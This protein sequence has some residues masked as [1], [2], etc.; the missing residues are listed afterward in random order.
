MPHVWAVLRRADGS[1]G[2]AG[3]VAVYASK[4]CAAARAKAGRKSASGV[5]RCWHERVEVRSDNSA[6][7]DE[8]SNP[9]ESDGGPSPLRSPPPARPH[10]PAD[11][12][13]RQ[14][15]V[16][17]EDGRY[18]AGGS[19]P[20]LLSVLRRCGVSEPVVGLA[21]PDTWCRSPAAAA[22][23]RRPPS[24]SPA[25]RKWCPPISPPAPPPPCS[26]PPADPPAECG[27][28]RWDVGPAAAVFTPRRAELIRQSA[29]RRVSGVSG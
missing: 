13:L 3:L 8:D 12:Q 16:S 10:H 28:V 26:P 19:P 14:L 17:V 15:A 27:G 6:D 21:D 24:V 7:T 20:Q 22:A 25:R 18:G 4:R 11:G 2:A 29:R 5:A 9:L 23:A 1:D